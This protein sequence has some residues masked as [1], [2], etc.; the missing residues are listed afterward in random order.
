[1]PLDAR[2]LPLWDPR[3][4]RCGDL[5]VFLAGDASG[6]LPLLH[7][8][9]DEGRIAGQ[10]AMLFPDLAARERRT[11]LAIAFTAPQMAAAGRRHA[12]LDVDAI[13]I[14]EA[15]F[16][17]QGRAVVMGENQG[18]VRLYAERQGARLV[19]AELFAPHA[20]HL[21]HLLA[22]AIQQGMRVPDVLRLPFYHPVLE[23][24]LRT[25]LR[26]L[27]SR[28]KVE[29]ETRCEDMATAPGA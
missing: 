10:N 15:G 7:E 12:E 2:G 6:H 5:P 20:E 19:G 21:A 29:R 8:A 26:E 22:W 27:A 25:A 28:T 14:G 17:D 23:E 1:M 9:A 3:T 18:L 24:G 4:T 11:P 16:E 13:E